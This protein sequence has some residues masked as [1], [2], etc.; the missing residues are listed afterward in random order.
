MST[1]FALAALASV[2]TAI[3]VFLHWYSYQCLKRS[4]IRRRSESP[5]FVIVVAG[6]VQ[7]FGSSGGEPREFRNDAQMQIGEAGPRF[8]ALQVDD[9]A[10]EINALGIDGAYE[11][12]Q[13]FRAARQGAE[14]DVRQP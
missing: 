12:K 5:E 8:H 14:V 6:N 1:S 2:I 11:V 10:D 3:V 4:I 13:V 7:D 9:V